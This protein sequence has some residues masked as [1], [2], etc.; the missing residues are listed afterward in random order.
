MKAA[1]ALQ[2]KSRVCVGFKG[3]RADSRAEIEV[4]HP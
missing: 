4:Q 1:E 3:F 2:G